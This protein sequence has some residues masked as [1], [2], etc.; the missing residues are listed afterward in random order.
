MNTQQLKQF[1]NKMIKDFW[2]AKRSCWSMEEVGYIFG[3]KIAQI[4]RILKSG[5][6]IKRSKAKN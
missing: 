4:Y 2:D 5:A 6:E 1:R 3:L